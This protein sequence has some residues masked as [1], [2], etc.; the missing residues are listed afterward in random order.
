MEATGLLE[1]KNPE[2][3]A[4]GG[5]ELFDADNSD[6]ACDDDIAYDECQDGT[7]GNDDDED[8]GDDAADDNGGFGV[9]HGDGLCR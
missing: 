2:D 6:D 3:K 4:A 7:E 5:E 8:G 9:E 1:A